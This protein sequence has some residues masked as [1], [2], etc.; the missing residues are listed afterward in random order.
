MIG[1]FDAHNHLQDE[2]LAPHQAEVI[3]TLERTGV[4]RWVVN[5]TTEADWDAVALLAKQNS[6]VLPSFGLH[7]WYLARRTPNW[8]D[9]LESHLN[10]GS[11]GVGEIGLDRW[12][13]GL[14]FE[15][16]KVVFKEQL[17]IAVARNLPVTIHCLKAFGALLEILRSEK[18]PERGFL[19]HSYGGSAEMIPEFV[20]LGA[21]FSFSGY[22]LADKK[23]AKRE[24]FRQ[25]PVE[26]LLVETDAPAMPLPAGLV[27][28]PLP[29]SPEGRPVNHPGNIGAV[30]E[31]LSVI[32]GM[33]LEELAARVEENFTKLFGCSKSNPK[34]A[35]CPD[36]E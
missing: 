17:E 23:A 12:M 22:F 20:E 7:P 16:Q 33:P 28:H 1:Y 14:D 30:Y 8:R 2:W 34:S 21:Y 13:D 4:Q 19:L 31:R 29:D 11:C 35:R 3:K 36:L 15:D 10:A 9:R 5:G 6:R 27:R 32:R 24:V 18:V 26:R 25:V